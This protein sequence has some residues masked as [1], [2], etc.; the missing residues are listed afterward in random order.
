MYPL[1]P[2][3]SGTLEDDADDGIDDDESDSDGS[4]DDGID[5]GECICH[6]RTGKR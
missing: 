2:P 5:D 1:P 4:D 6:T 3:C